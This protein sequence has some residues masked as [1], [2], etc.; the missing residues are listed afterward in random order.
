MSLSG[1]LRSI[2]NTCVRYSKHSLAPF[3][4]LLTVIFSSVVWLGSHA[5]ASTGKGKLC[6]F[7]E[8]YSDTQE[9]ITRGSI[10]SSTSPRF[11][12]S[13]S[14]VLFLQLCL[15]HVC[16]LT[17][18]IIGADL[19]AG[20]LAAFTT[21]LR[22]AMSSSLVQLHRFKETTL[23]WFM[24]DRSDDYEERGTGFCL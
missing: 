20:A 9:R 6:Q 14:P 13:M 19:S 10:P 22:Q 11:H 8:S 21:S 1:V 12:L 24:G 16:G 18:C 7:A 2:C 5:R 15:S 17:D 23:H 3:V 4:S